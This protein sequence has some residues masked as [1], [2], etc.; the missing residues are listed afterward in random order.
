LPKLYKVV[1]QDV[2]LDTKSI[3]TRSRTRLVGVIGGLEGRNK[4]G[5]TRRGGD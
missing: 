1:D 4:L 5:A 3:N 2:A